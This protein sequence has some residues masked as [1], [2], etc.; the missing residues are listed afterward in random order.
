MED[1]EDGVNGRII[2]FVDRGEALSEAVLEASARVRQWR[3]NP[4]LRP[5]T[6]IRSCSEQAEELLSIIQDVLE[7]RQLP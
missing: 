3:L 6:A 4:G 7:T 2:P 5:T 1:L